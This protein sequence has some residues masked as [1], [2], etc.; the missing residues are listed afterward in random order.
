MSV[1]PLVNDFAIL[2]QNNKGLIYKVANTYCQDEE[3]RKDL[4]QEITIQ[5]WSSF[6]SY[7]QTYKLSTWMYRVALNVAISHYR[8]DKKRRDNNAPFD[9]TLIEIEDRSNDIEFSEN[10][11]L[12][13]QFISELKTLEKALMLL[14]LDDKSYREISEIMNISETNVSTRIGRIKDKLKLRFTKI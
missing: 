13:Q 11:I 8:K 6:A 1:K 3:D 5:L 7:K 10:I 2:I 9:D 12:L 14:Y 4:I